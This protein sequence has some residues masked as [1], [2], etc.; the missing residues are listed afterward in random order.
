VTQQVARAAGGDGSYRDPDRRAE[1]DVQPVDP[2]RFEDDVLHPFG[3][4]QQVERVVL[5][6]E[7]GELVA[8]EPDGEC[9]GSGRGRDPGGDGLQHGVTGGVAEGVVDLFE[10]VQVEQQQAE[11]FGVAEPGGQAVVEGTPVRQAGEVIGA[12]QPRRLVE[13]ARLP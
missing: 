11:C 5:V 12:G 13:A 3:V 10:A 1:G 7:A 4:L 9:T 2:N 6:Q 8:P